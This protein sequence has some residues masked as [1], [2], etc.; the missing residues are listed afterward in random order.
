MGV[1]CPKQAMKAPCGFETYFNGEESQIVSNWKGVTTAE[2]FDRPL[3]RQAA[4]PQKRAEM[5]K[6]ADKLMLEHW[7][8]RNGNLYFDGF[9]GGYSLATKKDFGDF[10]MWADWRI[11]SI[12]G[13]SGLYLR[14][15]PQVQIWDA[16]NQWHIGSGGL[17]N[18]NYKKTGNISKALTIADRQV[19]D[20]NRFY[21][22]MVGNKVTVKLNGELVVDN[23]ALENLWDKDKPI[24]ACEQIELQCHGD[25]LEWRNIFIKSL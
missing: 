7:S 15:L 2:K 20:W 8:V 23:V 10:E 14:G 5:Q 4:T 17:Y 12:T 18:N 6:L 21:V 11:M 9:K 25:P 3:V 24:P 1:A 16:H 19:G 13:D 22:K